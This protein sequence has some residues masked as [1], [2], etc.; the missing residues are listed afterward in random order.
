MPRSR[1]LKDDILIE[2][3]MAA[4]RTPKRSAICALFRAAWSVR[5]PARRFWRRSSAASRATPRPCRASTANGAATAAG[6]TVELLKVL[7]RQVA[8]KQGVAAKMIATTDDLEA[9]ACDD[10]ADVGALKGWRRELFGA[11]A[12]QFKHGQLALTVENNRVVTL[13]YHECRCS[14]SPPRGKS[15]GGLDDGRPGHRPHPPPSPPPPPPPPL[16]G[17]P[18]QDARR[19]PVLSNHPQGRIVYLAPLP[20]HRNRQSPHRHERPRQLPAAQRL[21]IDQRGGGEAENRHQQRK[22]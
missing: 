17:D 5:A 10:N 11:K 1:V 7:L 19:P 20:E 3:A 4:P 2:V 9:L 15:I 16:G 8:E 21:M 13:E 14:L 6:R 22:A 12:L 18:K